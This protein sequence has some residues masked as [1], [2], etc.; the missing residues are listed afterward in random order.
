MVGWCSMGTFNDPWRTRHDDWNVT[1]RKIPEPERLLRCDF[2]CEIVCKC[3]LAVRLECS[4]YIYT[5]IYIYIY[6]YIYIYI[7]IYIHIYLFIYIYLYLYYIYKNK[8]YEAKYNRK[9]RFD[10]VHVWCFPN[11]LV[12]RRVLSPQRWFFQLWPTSYESIS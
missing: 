3:I 2:F 5:Y 12:S 7:Y 10:L 8:K 1:W 4:T 11:T 9:N 6:T